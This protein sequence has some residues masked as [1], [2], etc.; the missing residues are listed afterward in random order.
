MKFLLLTTLKVKEMPAKSNQTSLASEVTK[1]SKDFKRG[2]SACIITL[3]EEERLPRCLQSVSFVDE[4]IVIDSG[5]KDRTVEIAE[6]F[7]AQVI[8]REFDG[9]VNQ[10]NHAIKMATH[11][12]VLVIDADEVV[13]SKLASQIQMAA[14]EDE[15]RF[16]AFRIPRISF[17]LGRWIRYSG[18]YPD[19]NIRLFKNNSASFHGGTVHETVIPNGPTGTL[20]AHLEHYSYHDISDHLERIDTYSTLIA[21]DKFQKGR[22][23]GII[24]AILKG[25]SKFLLT[26]FYRR[27]I[28][29]G[30]AG[31]IIAVLGSYYNFLKYAKL[32]ELNRGLRNMKT[33][34]GQISGE[35][36]K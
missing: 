19:Y 6:S 28:L 33:M 31:L 18:W 8:E 5:S 26:Y 20:K 24:W 7:N 13:S 9:Y 4:I 11:K 35:N 32:W 23:S 14:A 29:D 2:I 16:T 27:G 1:E 25:C 30:R 12:W 36:K 22:K 34:R 15:T 17:Y 10:K 3:N 21:Q